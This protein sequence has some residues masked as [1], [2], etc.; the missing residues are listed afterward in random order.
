MKKVQS[1]SGGNRADLP[2]PTSLSTSLPHFTFFRASEI[3]L[4]ANVCLLVAYFCGRKEAL[5]KQRLYFGFSLVLQNSA[6]H[7]VCTHLVFVK[8]KNEKRKESG[9]KERNKNKE[10]K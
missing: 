10:R 3:I 6:W 1:G 9:K 5:W 4:N 8:G 2:T 7:I